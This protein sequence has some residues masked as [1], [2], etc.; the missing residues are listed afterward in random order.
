MKAVEP[1]M[2]FG[3]LVVVERLPVGG[4]TKSQLRCRCDCGNETIRSAGQLTYHQGSEQRCRECMRCDLT[5]SRIGRLTI[6]GRNGR[7]WLVKCAC[8]RLE[9]RTH[10]ALQAAKGRRQT[11]SCARCRKRLEREHGRKNAGEGNPNGRMTAARITELLEARW[12]GATP[13]ELATR[14]GLGPAY[15]KDIIRGKNWKSLPRP[16]GSRAGARTRRAA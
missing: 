8:G 16:W 5:G 9:R 1:G 11:S 14:F 4:E 15:V 6:V 12:D 7:D 2:R 10:R 3:H 13:D